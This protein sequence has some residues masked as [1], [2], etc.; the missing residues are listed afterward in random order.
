MRATFI[1]AC[2][3]HFFSFV[4]RYHGNVDLNCPYTE[5]L[6]TARHFFFLLFFFATLR[7][8]RLLGLSTRYINFELSSKMWSEMFEFR[9]GLVFEIEFWSLKV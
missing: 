2:S 5:I 9:S 1:S 7:A 4:R 3:A 8:M 6:S